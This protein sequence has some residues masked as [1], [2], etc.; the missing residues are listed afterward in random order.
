M[1]TLNLDLIQATLLQCALDNQIEQLLKSSDC[2]YDAIDMHRLC[3]IRN[4]ISDQMKKN[5]EM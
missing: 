3:E 5:L 2:V 4:S 1:I